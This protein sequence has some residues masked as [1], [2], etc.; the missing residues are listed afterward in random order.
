MSACASCC[1][2]QSTG[3]RRANLTRGSPDKKPK[4][5]YAPTH[6]EAEVRVYKNFYH[7][8]SRK[9]HCFVDET[10]FTVLRCQVPQPCPHH[11][12]AGD[13]DLL[14]LAT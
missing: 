11:L 13:D 5:S 10:S 4:G 3:K 9:D 8:S 1:G 14:R 7:S 12:A 6:V 2:W